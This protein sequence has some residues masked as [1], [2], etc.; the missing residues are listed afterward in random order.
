VQTVGILSNGTQRDY[1][2]M[3]HADVFSSIEWR[4]TPKFSV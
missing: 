1:P 3:V 2:A 4:W